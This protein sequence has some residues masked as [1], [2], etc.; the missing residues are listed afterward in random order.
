MN[1]SNHWINSACYNVCWH[2]SWHS[3]RDETNWYEITCKWETFSSPTCAV[4]IKSVETCWQVMVCLI[5]TQIPD[6][7]ENIW[8]SIEQCHTSNTGFIKGGKKRNTA[9]YKFGIC[10]CEA[11]L[12]LVC[13]LVQQ[14]KHVSI[15]QRSDIPYELNIV[16]PTNYVMKSEINVSFHRLHPAGSPLSDLWN[17]H[18]TVSVHL[19][20]WTGHDISKWIESPTYRNTSNMFALVNHW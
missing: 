2:N 5:T 12:E 15:N 18:F 16:P 10:L 9:I 1:C 17:K 13:L 20:E 4:F 6:E 3:T 19:K 11:Q 8:S 7:F 14:T